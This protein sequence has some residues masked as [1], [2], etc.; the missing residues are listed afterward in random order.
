MSDDYMAKWITEDIPDM[1][2]DWPTFNLR[3]VKINSVWQNVRSY[4]EDP[5]PVA[6]DIMVRSAFCLERADLPSVG[7]KYRISVYEAEMARRIY[8]AGCC[9]NSFALKMFVYHVIMEWIDQDRYIE[10][11]NKRLS[12]DRMIV[13]ESRKRK[14]YLPWQLQLFYGAYREYC[15]D[16]AK[17]RFAVILLEV[18]KRE[19]KQRQSQ[20]ELFKLEHAIVSLLYDISGNLCTDRD[21]CFAMNREEIARFIEFEAEVLRKR[22]LSIMERPLKGT[23]MIQLSNLILK[24]RCTGSPHRVYKYVSCENLKSSVAN[25][26]I[27]INDTRNL[28]DKFEGKVAQEVVDAAI[29]GAPKWVKRCKIR[30]HKKFY[31][32]CYSKDLKTEEL[33]ARYGECV[34]GYYGDRLVDYLGPVYWHEEKVFTK[35]GVV[36]EAYPVFSQ[37][38]VVDVIYDVDEAKKEL[39]YLIWCIDKL[40]QTDVE[41]R[42]F[43]SEILQYWKYSFKDAVHRVEPREEWIK[44]CERRYIIHY[45]NEYEYRGV[46]VDKKDSKLKFETMAVIA[47][48]FI[49]DCSSTSIREVIAKNLNSLYE[50]TSIPHYYVCNNCLAK[51]VCAAGFK[52]RCRECGSASVTKY[53]SK[54]FHL[55]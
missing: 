2:E 53:M 42:Q 23:L 30:Y 51:V 39:Q 10:E 16:W 35:G 33:G 9:F 25:R 48:D 52:G 19:L 37:V 45:Y 49:M 5:N 21:V 54:V 12:I 36:I 26:Q 20:D 13:T 22:K 40:G 55:A 29:I 8:A 34:L 47:P 28:N 17:R 11:C 27:W 4:Y 38:Y 46:I 24:S 41:K 6:R 1:P 31:V 50:C 32:G 15:E 14:I 43:Y 18:C 7:P 3:E 44:E